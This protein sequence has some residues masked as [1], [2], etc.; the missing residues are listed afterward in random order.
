M[1]NQ[2]KN[3]I[4]YNGTI[5][6]DLSGDTVTLPE[7]IMAGFVGHLADGMQVT[8]TG[9]GGGTAA[10]S[11]V[12][13]EDSHGGTIRTITALDI[14][15][16]T[17]VAADVAQGKY[18]YTANG[19]KTAG[20]ASGSGG[21]EGQT[22][23][24][25]VTGSGTTVLEIP[26]SFEPDL[27]H[28]YGDLSGD[29]SLR[30][31]T[32]LTIIKDVVIYQTQDGSSGSANESTVLI[33]DITGYN[34]SDTEYTH[35]S[36]SNGTLTIDTVSNSA[37]Y[38]FTE[39]ITYSYELSTI[40][41]GGSS[42]PSATSHSIYFEFS[43]GTNT[44]LT[45]YDNEGT[46]INSAITSTTPT[47]YGSKTVTLAQLDGVTWY[48][49][50]NIPLNTQLI[51]F[52]AVL[53]G[54]TVNNGSVI[55]SDAWNCVTD[56]IL[57]DPTMTFSFKCRQYSEIGF[58]DTQKNPISIAEADNIKE[59]AED[60]VAFGYLTPSIIPLNAAYVVLC[61]NTY[62]IEDTLSLIRTA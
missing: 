37:G 36:Y 30:G 56:Y 26:C 38:R 20:T 53:T 32:T 49:P 14:S 22:A 58:Y 31:I 11:V 62:G 33:R 60:Y 39:G 42:T 8:G 54:Y 16:T 29:V 44:T 35:A 3:K 52:N 55:T 46:F 12:D 45:Y 13:T 34:E 19:T 1:A 4:V 21:S 10:I 24:G 23:T 43:D 25:T 41:A 17:A 48:E 18:F 27:I 7:H 61:G 9:Q 28:L 57:I 6:L 40:G 2:Y 51:D 47:T 59:S 50:M 15:D 5:L